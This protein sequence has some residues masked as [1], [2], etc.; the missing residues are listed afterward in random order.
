VPKGVA[1]DL[2]PLS[3]R[4]LSENQVEG[5]EA[6]LEIGWRLARRVF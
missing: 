4:P 5:G 1:S 3:A 6:K 2:S